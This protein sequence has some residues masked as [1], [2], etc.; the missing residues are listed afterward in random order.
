M[1]SIVPKMLLSTEC[2]VLTFDMARRNA[3]DSPIGPRNSFL[4]VPCQ[5]QHTHK[6]F[7]VDKINHFALVEWL[8]QDS[9]NITF[10]MP[11]RLRLLSS[12]RVVAY[13]TSCFSSPAPP[14]LHE[15]PSSTVNPALFVSSGFLHPG[16]PGLSIIFTKERCPAITFSSSRH[17]LQP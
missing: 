9:K 12:F 8:M 4:A 1:K 2:I 5:Y 3:R 10:H 17:V 15:S 7:V 6:C 16:Y 11:D 14:I 13:S